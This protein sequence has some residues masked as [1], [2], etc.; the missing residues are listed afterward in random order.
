MNLDRYIEELKSP[1]NV[2]CG[3][4]TIAGVAAVAGIL[5]SLWQREGWHTGQVNPA[6]RLARASSS[7]TSRRQSSSTCCWSAILIPFCPGTVAER[8]LSEDDTRLYGPGV[9]DMKS[10]LLNILWAMRE[11]EPADKDR[12]AIAVA[13]NPDEETGS[14]YSPR[15][16]R[17]AGTTLPLCA[18]VRS[19]PC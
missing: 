13:M 1:V 12:P 3:T 15:M 17:C 14:V 4:Q 18:G 19:C 2:D 9:S 16:D 7:A 5:E 11:L 8:P 10:G 6:R